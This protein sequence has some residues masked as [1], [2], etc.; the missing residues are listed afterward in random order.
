M[1]DVVGRF[2]DIKQ[3]DKLVTNV[4]AGFYAGF[5]ATAPSLHVGHLVPIMILGWAY[6]HG[7]KAYYLVGFSRLLFGHEINGFFAPGAKNYH[8]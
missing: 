8:V 4:R 3:L 7:M 5:D 2:R 1:T 6:L